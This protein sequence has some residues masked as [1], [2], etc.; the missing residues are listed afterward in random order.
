[1]AGEIAQTIRDIQ[2]VFELIN[3]LDK[4]L[5]KIDNQSIKYSSIKF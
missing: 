5:L 3:W 2:Q 4:F 1:M